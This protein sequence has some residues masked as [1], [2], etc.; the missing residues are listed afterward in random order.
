MS[1]ILNS[2]NE[3]RG[4]LINEFTML[5]RALDKHLLLHFYPTDDANSRSHYRMHEVLLD[6][7]TFDGKRTAV[8]GILDNKVISEGFKK[9]KN[10]SYP[11]SKILG[12]VRELIEIRN[13]FAHYLTVID[14]AKETVITLLQFRDSTKLLQYTQQ[15]FDELVERIM[16]ATSDVL[17]LIRTIQL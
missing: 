6:R 12:E 3:Y 5:E 15:D 7:M 11:H 2:V 4:Y 8:K 9:T 1:I 14:H 13:F 17:G 16:K 10:K